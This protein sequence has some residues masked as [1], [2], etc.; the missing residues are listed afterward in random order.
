MAENVGNQF[1]QVLTLILIPVAAIIVGVILWFKGR[2]RKDLSFLTSCTT[3]LPKVE[4]TVRKKLKILY[5]EKEVKQIYLNTVTLLCSG[6][7]P[8]RS[9]DYEGSIELGFGNTVE[10]LSAEIV[11]PSKRCLEPS[12]NVE[13]G[14]VYLVPILMNHGDRIDMKILTESRP[15]KMAIRARIA[16]IDEVKDIDRHQKTSYRLQVTGRLVLVFSLSVILPFIGRFF[17]SV[18]FFFSWQFFLFLI[19]I[20]IGL[21]LTAASRFMAGPKLK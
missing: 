19:L 12:F 3:V 5:E 7:E 4:D 1:W 6:N 18:N 11:K 13:D 17:E 20:S 8:I 21:S 16:G 14:S 2:R 9:D 10:I 15:Q